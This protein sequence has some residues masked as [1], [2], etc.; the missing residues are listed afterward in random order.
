MKKIITLFALLCT[1]FTLSAGPIGESRAREI[2]EEF[3][4]LN[5]TRSGGGLELEWAGDAITDDMV[6][7]SKLDKSLMYIY[8]LTGRGGYV[9]V[10]GD[11]SVAPIVAFSFD[12]PFDK[13]NMADATKAILD[14]WCREIGNARMTKRSIDSTPLA[15]TRA[16]ELI[17]DTAIWNQT[18]PYNREAPVYDGYRCYTGCVATA[19]SIICYYNRWP[20]SGVGTT[21]AYTYTDYGNVERHVAANTLGRTYNYNNMLADYNNGFTNAQGNA[22]AALMKDIGTAVQMMYHYTGSGAMDAYAL[23]GITNHFRYNKGAKLEFRESYSYKEW[24]TVLK[25]NLKSCGPTYYSGASADGGGHAFVVDG[26]VGDYFHFNFGWGGANNGY[27]LT[28]NITYYKGQMAMFNL[29]PDRTGDSKCVDNLVLCSALNTDGETVLRGIYSESVFYQVGV[30]EEYRIGGFY[31]FGPRPFNGTVNLVHC[32]KDG[33]WKEVL[34]TFEIADLDIH[35]FTYHPTF[36]RLAL[37]QS[38]ETGDRIRIYYCSNDS[39]EWQ[40]AKR[41]DNA[42]ANEIILCATPEEVAE[43]IGFHYDKESGKIYIDT[44]NAI[45]IDMDNGWG[46]SAFKSHTRVGVPLSEG[47]HILKISSGGE[48]YILYIKR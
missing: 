25:Q 32:T 16:E 23:R 37:S 10:A 34:F 24:N 40:W 22:V 15:L 13:D 6:I 44:T 11:D 19:L 42:A 20:E 9:V 12:A 29:T 7:A 47:E 8:N 14:G 26:Y 18:E 39:N 30:D 45:Q 4:T 2:A 43:A 33:E 27:F 36:E 31:N 3:F 28:P 48:P 17:Y 1:V 21:E 35:G 5:T 41:Y 46:T 38:I